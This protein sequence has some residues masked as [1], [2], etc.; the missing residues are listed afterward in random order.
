MQMV[1]TIGDCIYC[2]HELLP[3]NLIKLQDK[4]P[5]TTDL[6]SLVYNDF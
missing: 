4:L 3:Y 1:S 2:M 6:E 5:I